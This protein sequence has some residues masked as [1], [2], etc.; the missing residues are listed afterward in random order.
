MMEQL[1]ESVSKFKCDGA[2]LRVS[3]HVEVWWSK[4][5]SQWASW[6]VMEQLFKSVSKLKCDGATFQ[7]SEQVQVW[8]SNIS[9]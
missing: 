1:F 6:S 7:F 9:N 5:T 2:R 3:E 4:I 8:W